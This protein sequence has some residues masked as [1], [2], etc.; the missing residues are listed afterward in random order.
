MFFN[1]NPRV[2]VEQYEEEGEEADDEVRIFWP[3]LKWN[4][5]VQKQYGNKGFSLVTVDCW[6]SS[7][8]LCV[9][10]GEEEADEE[11]DPDYDP[12]VRSLNST[13]TRTHTRTHTPP[14]LKIS[15]VPRK[16]LLSCS[17]LSWLRML[18]AKSKASPN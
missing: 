9:Q 7:S 11:N 3:Q 5:Y 17:E 15:D 16:T 12:K 13:D 1:S 10:E 8:V 6:R 2:F 4:K 14:S 18:C